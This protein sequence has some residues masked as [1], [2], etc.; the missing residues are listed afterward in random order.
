MHPD[1]ELPRAVAEFLGDSRN[2]QGLLFTFT[3]LPLFSSPVP[4]FVPEFVFTF[5]LDDNADGVL[6][7]TW[8]DGVTVTLQ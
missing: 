6:D 2:P 7:Q 5:Y 1:R 8:S 4:P 3:D